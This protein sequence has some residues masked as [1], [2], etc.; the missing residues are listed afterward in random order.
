M[1]LACDCRGETP[2]KHFAHQR[3]ALKLTVMPSSTLARRASL[4]YSA[5]TPSASPALTRS[6][7]KRLRS[8]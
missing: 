7:K 8:S 6:T 2:I 4:A 3:P 1:S 5:A